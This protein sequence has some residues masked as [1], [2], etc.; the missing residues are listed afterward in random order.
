MTATEKLIL[1]L[2]DQMVSKSLKKTQAGKLPVYQKPSIYIPPP[3][4]R[5]IF[6]RVIYLLTWALSLSG[7]FERRTIFR[8]KET[9][10]KCVATG[11]THLNVSS[12]E[13]HYPSLAM[14]FSAARDVE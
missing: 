3:T 5:V 1:V 7:R 13:H 12:S 8:N 4:I 6:V 10:R 11:F 14:I 2:S 9:Q